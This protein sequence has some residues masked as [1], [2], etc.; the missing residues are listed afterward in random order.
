MHNTGMLIKL[1]NG[2]YI[3]EVLLILISFESLYTVN[4]K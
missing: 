4:G 2:S 1:H 3:M